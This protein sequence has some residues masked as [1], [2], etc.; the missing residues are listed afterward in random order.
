LF[1]TNFAITT[2]MRHG[3]VRR[4]RS[5]RRAKAGDASLSLALLS[6]AAWGCFAYL[7]KASATRRTA[8]VDHKLLDK[9]PEQDN[10]PVHIAAT[11]LNP[12]GKWW[13]YL[14]SSIAIAFRMAG[15]LRKQ[16]RSSSRSSAPLTVASSALLSF[17]LNE[18]FDRFLP[19]PPAPPGHANRNKPVYPSGHMFGPLSLG[20]TLSY[21]LAREGLVSPALTLPSALA[22][23]IVS[24][25]SRLVMR[26]HWMSDAAGGLIGGIAVASACLAFYE[27]NRE[28]HS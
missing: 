24:A 19:Q 8:A 11:V 22:V 21:T 16:R 18:A 27:L 7:A 23:P 26:K 5:K 4:R 13:A 14:P 28:L 25:G 17:A 10:K 3:I 20:L 9:M 2:F 1:G 15:A 12:L 6:V